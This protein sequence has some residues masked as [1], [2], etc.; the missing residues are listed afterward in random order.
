M[1][2]TAIV[3]GSAG[4]IGLASAESLVK[5]G[6]NVVMADVNELDGRK[7]SDRLGA[8]FL[9][10]DLTSSE[11]CRALV[12][13]TI[14][15]FG[16][17]DILIN[18]AGVQC[19]SPISEFPESRWDTILKLML[20]APFLL[21][22]YVWP[23]MEKSNWGRIVN[24]CSVHGLRA[25]EYK[26]AYVSAKHGLRGLTKVS[27]LEGGKHG[28]TC[29]TICPAYVQTPLVEKQLKSQAVAHGISEDEVIE[30]IFLKKSAIKRMVPPN[31]IASAVLYLCSD[32]ASSITGTDLTIDCGWTAA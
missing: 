26:A 1:S 2:R 7:E 11:S 18:N 22:K 6:C 24:V 31:E 16:G 20:T 13:Y 9:R 15:E 14:S 3:T 4:G 25:S 19:V 30:N 32:A 27:A 17:V 21:T 12:D 29:N 8:K 5:S 28:I 10:T 23:H